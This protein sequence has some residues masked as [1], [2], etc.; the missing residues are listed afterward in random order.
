MSNVKTVK[1]A[2]AI[3]K[4][5]NIIIK[6]NEFNEFVVNFKGGKEATAYYTMDLQDAVDTGVLMAAELECKQAGGHTFVERSHDVDGGFTM[7][8][9]NCGLLGSGRF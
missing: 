7:E 8:C 2:I 5:K 3:L 4:P 9:S 1:E 6:R